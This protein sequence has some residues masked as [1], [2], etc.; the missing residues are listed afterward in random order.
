MVAVWEHMSKLLGARAQREWL[1]G[2]GDPALWPTC[3]LQ[4]C[5]LQSQVSEKV[6]VPITLLVNSLQDVFAFR[7]PS[8]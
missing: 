6:V 5:Q 7:F 3:P 8:C 2:E 1:V 4:G